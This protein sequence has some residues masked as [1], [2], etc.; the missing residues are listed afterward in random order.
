LLLVSE[1]PFITGKLLQ[2][3]TSP[4]TYGWETLY[5]CRIDKVDIISLRSKG[6]S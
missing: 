2:L 3:P 1:P 6:F 5:K 4:L